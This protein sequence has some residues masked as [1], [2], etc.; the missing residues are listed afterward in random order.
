MKNRFL[1]R[2]P[3]QVLLAG[4][5]VLLMSFGAKAV[6]M[7]SW[8]DIA[9]FENGDTKNQLRW[10]V[11]DGVIPDGL[12]FGPTAFLTAADGKLYIADVLNFRLLVCSENGKPVGEID[13][14]RIKKTAA[15]EHDPLVIDLVLREPGKLYLA[16]AGN[17]R[18]LVVTSTGDFLRTV[19]KTGTGPGE[20]RQINKIHTDET[21]KV[22]VE[23][24]SMARTIAFTPRGTFVTAYQGLTS[25]AVDTFGNIHQIVFDGDV[26]S[27]NVMI[28]DENGVPVELLG[29]IL[30]DEDIKYVKPVGFDAGSSFY[31]TYDTDR[32]RYYVAFNTEGAISRSIRTAPLDEGIQVTTP[33]WV[34]PDGTIYTIQAFPD[35]FTIKKLVTP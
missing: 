35:K 17:N 22:Y 30:S 21:G 29:T 20:F 14:K 32:H 27:R 18:V 10:V 26:K 6:E 16:D 31:V 15:L 11:E 1:R 3:V 28:Y 12:M 24:L 34:A 13:L 8:T 25:V 23:D 4:C 7:G 2:V 5:V 9:S 19:G 33:D